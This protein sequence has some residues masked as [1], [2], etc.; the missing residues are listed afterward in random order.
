MTSPVA[1][2]SRATGCSALF[3]IALLHIVAMCYFFV[4][5]WTTRLGI[6]P[7][8][9]SWT[10]GFLVIY[11]LF[12]LSF[13]WCLVDEQLRSWATPVAKEKKDEP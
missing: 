4:A 1:L 6:D 5:A 3:L 7:M 12:I 11:P 9:I 10:Y 8:F 2:H 13:H